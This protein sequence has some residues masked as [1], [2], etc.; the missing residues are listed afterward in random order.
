MVKSISPINKT[1][2]NKLINTCKRYYPT[3]VM[4]LVL[5]GKVIIKSSN[6]DAITSTI[7]N[8]GDEFQLIC[9]NDN[10]ELGWFVLCPYERDINGVI[11]DVAETDFSYKYLMKYR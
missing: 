4:E 2:I 6:R 9:Y 11:A 8:D 7:Y 5:D 3:M 10:M 1:L